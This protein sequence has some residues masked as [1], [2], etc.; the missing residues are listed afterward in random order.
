M[1]EAGREYVASTVDGYT[2]KIS[3]VA[4]GDSTIP[5]D[6]GVVVGREAPVKITSSPSETTKSVEEMTPVERLTEVLYLAL[7]T[8]VK[9]T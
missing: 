7:R 4:N 3:M 9:I 2:F 6:A 1:I 8:R 5:V